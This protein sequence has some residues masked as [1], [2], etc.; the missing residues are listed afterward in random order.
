METRRK[1]KKLTGKKNTSKKKEQMSY[2]PLMS[3][4]WFVSFLWDTVLSPAKVSHP[5]LSTEKARV[6]AL[7][8]FF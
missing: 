1:K 5:V 6:N 7:Q 8:L 4:S 2:F 3:P